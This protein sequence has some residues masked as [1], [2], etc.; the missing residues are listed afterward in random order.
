MDLYRGNC[1]PYSRPEP[2]VR[3]MLF[4]CCF[5]WDTFQTLIEYD[6]RVHLLDR[7]GKELLTDLPLRGK[8]NNMDYRTAYTINHFIKPGKPQEYYDRRTA[9]F[10][11]LHN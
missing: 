8:G 3:R 5:F 11:S 10:V 1:N 6:M 2:N 9:R 7:H 4:L